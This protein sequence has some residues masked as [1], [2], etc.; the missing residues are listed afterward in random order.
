MTPCCRNAT[1]THTSRKA[2]R[3]VVPIPAYIK[4]LFDKNNLS[5]PENGEVTVTCTGASCIRIVING[6]VHN[7]QGRLNSGWGGKFSN[8]SC[9]E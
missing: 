2:P 3:T 4:R 7:V 6:A 5:F 8:G 9:I 1:N